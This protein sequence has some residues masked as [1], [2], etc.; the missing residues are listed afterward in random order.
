MDILRVYGTVLESNGYYDEAIQAYER[1]LEINPNLTFLYLRI[2]SNHRRQGRIEQALTA[3]DR[4][5][6]IN[7]QLG[8]QDPVP[9][10]AIG[11]TYL[12]EGQFF[13]AARNLESAVRIAPSDPNLLGFLGIIYFKA[14]N[15]EF[16]ST[17]LY[18]AVQGCSPSEQ[19]LALCAAEEAAPAESAAGARIADSL[20]SMSILDCNPA[21]PDPRLLGVTPMALESSTLEYYY[22][23]AS[24]LAFLNLCEDAAQVFQDLERIYAT[25]PIV[26]SIV[27]EGRG[28]CAGSASPP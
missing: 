1:A 26:A 24:V 19:A 3:F 10:L 4:A 7:A 11:R 18:C 14:R 9:Y 27:A 28:L 22:T 25:D 12:Q 8:L 20:Q 15:Y 6:T 23:Y 21:E 13:I 16:A 5:A 17:A 2:G